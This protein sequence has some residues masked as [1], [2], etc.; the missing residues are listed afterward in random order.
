VPRGVATP[1]R[2][3]P[4]AEP[5]RA[6]ILAEVGVHREA[7][8][9]SLGRCERCEVVG[10]AA[11]VE[12]AVAALEEVE[13]E[14]VL[15]DMPAAE[16]TN[17]VRALVAADREVKVVALAVSEVERD[18]IAFAEAG[19]AGYVAREGSMDDLVE[20][21]ESVSRGEVLVSPAIAAKLFRRVATTA[22]EPADERLTARELDVLGLLET[23]LSNKEIAKTLSIELP[24]VKNHVHSVL[25]K[26]DVRCRTAAAA[27]AR[28]LGLLRR[29][30]PEANDGTEPFSG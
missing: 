1:G 25:E 15:V 24:T 16:A 26:L 12:E 22:R 13:P 23:G 2:A 9:R 21:V 28:R 29:G 27:R 14:I 4:K 20:V 3:T 18:V 17:A 11:S 19:A 8:A 6:L 10:V 7:L 30:G 5:L